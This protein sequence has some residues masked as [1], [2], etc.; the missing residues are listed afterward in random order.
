MCTKITE[1]KAIFTKTEMNNKWSPAPSTQL[2]E[3]N[4]YVSSSFFIAFPI[5]FDAIEKFTKKSLLDFIKIVCVL[6][7]H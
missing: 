1:I 7:N 4:N 3:S 2:T 5:T 6:Q